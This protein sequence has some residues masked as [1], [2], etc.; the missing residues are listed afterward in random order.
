M[1]LKVG[2]MGYSS[3]SADVTSEGEAKKPMEAPPSAKKTESVAKGGP[4][5]LYHGE[6]AHRTRVTI[7]RVIPL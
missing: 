5:R 2:M 3:W 6:R 7:T 4:E 1:Y